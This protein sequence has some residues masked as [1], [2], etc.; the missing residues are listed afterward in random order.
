MNSKCITGKPFSFRPVTATGV[1]D[2]IFTLDDTKSSS[3]DIPLRILKGHK[4]SQKYYVN[5]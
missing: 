5:G 1:L 2:V 4:I 3:G